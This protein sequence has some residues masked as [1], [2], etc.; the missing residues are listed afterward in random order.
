MHIFYL[1]KIHL[2]EKSETL[3]HNLSVNI[4]LIVTGHMHNYNIQS[5]ISSCN[6][7]QARNLFEIN[8]KNSKETSNC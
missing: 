7:Q 3:L 2:R 4:K 6:N 8:Y 1:S 5:I